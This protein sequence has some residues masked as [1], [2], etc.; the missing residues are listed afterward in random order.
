MNIR[1]LKYLVALSDHQHFG[2]AADACFVSQPAL[3]MQIKKLE[4]HLGVKL[5]E[6]NNKS[7][8]LTTSGLAIV[9]RARQILNQVEELR[10]IAKAAKDPFSGELK[11]G[12][13]PTL[14]PY[15]LPRIMPGLAKKFPK[16]SLYLIEEQTT[17]LLEMLKQGKLDAAFIALPPDSTNFTAV[18][19]FEE[20]FL[21]AAAA[22]HPLAKQATIK[23]QQLNDKQ[24]LLLDDG[25]CMRT[26]ALALCQ[27]VHAEEMQN[28]RATSLETLRYMVAAGL[29]IT[30][31]PQLAV[32]TDNKS[33]AYI[34]FA[35]PRPTRTIGLVWRTGTA[36]EVLFEKFVERVKEIMEKQKNIKVS[37]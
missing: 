13:F 11:I 20:E 21:L 14:G 4:T 6:R 32:Q 29:G 3:S 7:M 18:P 16:L 28:F 5:I 35:A 10:E 23:Q 1:D 36:R 30:L 25:H 24:L 2:K 27:R 31:M 12:I 26:Q 34:P 15:L 33:I 22:T 37:S 9:E 17:L 8:L 19:L